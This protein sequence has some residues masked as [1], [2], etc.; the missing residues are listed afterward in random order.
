MILAPSGESAGF[1]G[2][3]IGSEILRPRW[4][5]LPL[6]MLGVLAPPA[7]AQVIRGV[8]VEAELQSPVTGTRIRAPIE[9]AEVELLADQGLEPVG[10]VTDSLGRF[11]LLVPRGGSYGL[12]VSHLAFRRYESDRF[13]V[14]FSETVSIEVRLG[15]EVI[16]LEPLVVTARSESLLAGFNQRRSMGGFGDFLTREDIESRG[17]QRATDL[18]RGMPG[19]SLNFVRWGQ[20]PALVM[21]DGFGT[22]EPAIWV[23]G[24]RAPQFSG[25]GVNDFLTPDR[26][27]AVEVYTSFSAAPSQYVSSTCGVILFWT[28]RGGTDEDASPWRWKRFLGGLGIAVGL[29]LW[30]R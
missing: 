2:L 15:H 11:S 4:F 19:L 14:G 17:A 5:A 25:S 29:I 12:R 26:I 20:G 8:V 27:E 23:D 7:R 1:A 9:G 16:P 10:A 30:V 28:R 21:R 3:G 24:M 22:C 6:L 18:L 13:E